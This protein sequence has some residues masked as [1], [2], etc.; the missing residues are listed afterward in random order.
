MTYFTLLFSLDPFPFVQIPFPLPPSVQL[1]NIYPLKEASHSSDLLRRH[2][3]YL[4]MVF[5]YGI[6]SL[7]LHESTTEERKLKRRIHEMKADNSGQL[8]PLENM[9]S[10]SWL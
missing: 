5:L 1:K 4:S 9:P 7:S 3:F 6:L 10:I 8:L 2:L